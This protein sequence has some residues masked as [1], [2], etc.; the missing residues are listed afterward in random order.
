MNIIAITM[1]MVL[2]IYGVVG[3]VMMR[4]IRNVDSFYIMEEKAP[5]LFLVCGICMAYISAVTMSGGPSVCYEQGPFVLLTFAQPG[6]WL[7]MVVAIL[8]IGRKMKSIGCYTMPDYFVKRFSDNNVTFLSVVIMGIGLELYGVGQ[9]IS[10]GNILSDVT[11]LSYEWLVVIFTIAM[12]MFCVPGGIWSIMVTDIFMFVVVFIGVLVVCP[13]VLYNITPEALPNLTSQFWSAGGLNQLPISY[14]IS[15][16]MLWFM[17]FAGSPVIITR[18]F[19]AKNDFD[20]FKACIISVALIAVMSAVIYVTAGM[21]R[22]VEP[23]IVQTEKV[24][25]QAYMNHAPTVL[26]LIGIAGVLTAAIS[27]AA[28]VFELVGFALSRD[29]YGILNQNKTETKDPVKRARLAQFF[30]VA[31]GGFIAYFQPVGNFDISVFVTG[32]FASGWLPVILLSLLWK[33]LNSSGAFYGMLSG[34]TTLIIMQ[35][36]VVYGD[37]ELPY[38]MN[39]Y[40]I[41]ITL[42]IVVSILFSLNSPATSCEAINYFRIQN[43]LPSDMILRIS[44]KSP[45]ALSKLFKDYR[46]TRVIIIGV[47]VISAA[48]WILIMAWSI[49]FLP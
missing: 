42:A 40:V 32:I 29:L 24:M 9:L 30:V 10:L 17:F 2:L 7:G 23:T 26:G 49:Y 15:L 18:V 36:L 11:G 27:T 6:A 35:V 13:I 28:I 8:F 1:I 5:T 21:M 47:V 41:S 3:L 38:S 33:R 12:I 19:P 22:G 4:K 14:N 25:L 16:F 37:V 46:L 20:V 34:I 43:T 44:R 31:L 48:I 45:E 39:Q